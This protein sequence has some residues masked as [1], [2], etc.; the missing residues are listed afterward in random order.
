VV[1]S[2]LCPSCSSPVK[3]GQILCTVCGELLV[4]AGAPLPGASQAEASPQPEAPQPE[5]SQ[6]EAGPA[7]ADE[8]APT[9]PA[10]AAIDLTAGVPADPRLAAIGIE[11]AAPG[12]PPEL[13]PPAAEQLSTPAAEQSAPAAEQSAPAAEQ[14]AP[15]AAPSAQQSEPAEDVSRPSLA[16][17]ASPPGTPAPSD[18]ALH[19]SE[20]GSVIRPNGSSM[21]ISVGAVPVSSIGAS[22]AAAPASVPAA[23]SALWP[24]AP[25]VSDT[26]TAESAPAPALAVPPAP[27]G[28]STP[29]FAA[30]AG[31]GQPRPAA[32]P[33]PAAQPAPAASAAPPASPA[34]LAA[35]PAQ[36]AAQP[37]SAPATAAPPLTSDEPA[38][39]E[40]VRE[41]VAF[42]LVAAGAVIGIFSLFFPWANELGTS[43][44]MSET[45][46]PHQW[47]WGM[48]GGIPIFLLGTLVLG[49]VA[50]CDRAQARLPNLSREIGTVANVV[51]PMILGGL[52]LGIFLLYWGFPWG[53]GGGL[54]VLFLGSVLLIAGA[55]AALFFPPEVPDQ[56]T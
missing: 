40:S 49:A 3:P 6:P 52:C 31:Y 14:S 8:V 46:S 27:A 12:H 21:S 44:M 41:L 13:T 1:E 47:G 42:G 7:P 19:P 48:P 17:H 4:T 36:P 38:T 35:S 34:A 54:Y 9:G 30:S 55:L 39:R 16:G 25:G 33:A 22:P 23:Q 26:R 18:W 29:P 10:D 53:F 43:V 5:A 51:M 15:P 24:A 50:G 20:A 2:S 56:Q 11:P 45:T 28:S 32:P 37:A